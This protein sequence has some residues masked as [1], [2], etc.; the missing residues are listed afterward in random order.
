V[1]CGTAA[2][3]DQR[4]LL[5]HEQHL[6]RLAHPVAFDL[7]DRLLQGRPARRVPG[8]G[9]LVAD[10]TLLR[11]VLTD[12]AYRKD[13]PGSSGALWSG[14]LGYRTLIGMDGPPHRAL[15]RA[16][17]QLFTPQ[18]A[19]QVCERVLTAPLAQLTD[20][21]VS[22][23]S[24]DVVQATRL[25]ATSVIA[26]IVGMAGE[27]TDLVQQR[28]AAEQLL[29]V[30]DG[31]LG[32]VR[33]GTRRLSPAQNRRLR[34]L[35]APVA[36]SATAAYDR[37]VRNEAGGGDSVMARLP[38]LGISRSHAPA[39]AAVLLLTGTETMASAAPRTVAMLHDSGMLAELAARDPGESRRAAMTPF[40]AEALRLATPSPAMLRRATCEARIGPVRVRRG[41]RMLLATWW[42]TRQPGGFQPGRTC[43]AAVRNLWFGA[44]P[45][46]CLG[47]AL[48]LAEL[49]AITG[50]VLDAER[51]VGGVR[52]AQR[53]GARRVL[54]P[55]YRRLVLTA[56]ATA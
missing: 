4:E 35:F 50:A 23:R 15:R 5:A 26:T 38:A 36:E 44:G 45:H 33:L 43:P 47:S 13:G 2:A 24:V 11:E 3:P 42:A 55:S 34:A 9:V 25:A 21:L 48:A 37:A 54:V 52:V 49:E 7:L 1:T 32:M 17:G 41:E 51:A 16:V 28:Q 14:V 39:L 8:L 29:R 53:E 10:P 46:T 19:A 12:N 22:G 27:E 6:M 31:V 20:D 30:S 18:A 56:G 40:I